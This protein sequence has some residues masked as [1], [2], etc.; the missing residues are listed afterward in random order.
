MFVIAAAYQ[1]GKLPNNPFQGQAPA[2][3]AIPGNAMVPPPA[4][5]AGKYSIRTIGYCYI[6]ELELSCNRH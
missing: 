6:V 1:Q 5:L 4:N 2:P 3:G